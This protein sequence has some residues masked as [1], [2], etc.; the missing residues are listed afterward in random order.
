MDK[1]NDKV[2]KAREQYQF[3]QLNEKFEDKDE[4]KKRKDKL[5]KISEQ[6]FIEELKIKKQ[7]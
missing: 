1:F 6:I 5:N 2:E 3:Q 4:N 7:K